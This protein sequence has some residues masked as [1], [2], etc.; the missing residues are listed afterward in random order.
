MDEYEREA[1]DDNQDQVLENDESQQRSVSNHEEELGSINKKQG[2]ICV[3]E[4]TT[5]FPVVAELK[6]DSL[7]VSN[8]NLQKKSLV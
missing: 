7:Q 3:Q 5:K 1:L 4:S 2:S 6:D 8:V